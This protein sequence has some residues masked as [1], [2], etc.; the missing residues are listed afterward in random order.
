[1]VAIGAPFQEAFAEVLFVLADLAK[2]IGTAV[3]EGGALSPVLET[4]SLLVGLMADN[5]ADAVTSIT[6]FLDAAEGGFADNPFIVWLQGLIDSSTV[7]DE[8][9][10]GIRDVKENFEEFGTLDP[11]PIYEIVEKVDA[12]LFLK[13]LKDDIKNKLTEVF[14]GT[15]WGD[16]SDAL[17]EMIN[18]LDFGDVGAAGTAFYK[19]VEKII[20]NHCGTTS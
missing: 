8:V 6:G 15:D 7:I 1:M 13:N 9:L 18:S 17:V 12:D 11:T 5:F 3:E 14:I 10:V 2:W 16:V 20:C 19:S 4:I